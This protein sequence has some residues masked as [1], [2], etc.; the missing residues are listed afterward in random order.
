MCKAT[1][2]GDA[3]GLC[4]TCD[5]LFCSCVTFT[6][7]TLQSHV[8]QCGS[9]MFQL[10]STISPFFST[11]TVKSLGVIGFRW[12]HHERLARLPIPPSTPDRL[13]EATIDK[14]SSCLMLLKQG[15]TLFSPH[16]A[17]A[18]CC[19]DEAAKKRQHRLE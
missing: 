7:L 13:A 3:A 15:S 5:V 8:A 9:H 19:C 18:P 6:F 12:L 14:A 11:S 4:L 16:E 1:A 17:L 10:Y 2:N